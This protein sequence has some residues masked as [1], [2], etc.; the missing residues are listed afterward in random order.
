[1]LCD[2]HCHFFSEGFLSALA[3]QRGRREPT[4][5]LVRELQWEPPGSSAALADRWVRELDAHGVAR[6]ALIGSV[7][8][9]EVQVAEA[10]ARHPKRFVGF[11]MVDPAAADAVERTRRGLMDHHLA[12]VCLFPAMHGVPLHDVRT[13]R[14]LEVIGSNAGVAAFVHCGMLSVGVRKKL[15]LPSRFDLRL[16][17]P[18][19]LQPLAAAYPQI[20]FIIPHFGGGL[21]REALIAA[22]A[23]ENVH[24]DTS[25]SNR[26]I[27][28]TPGLTLQD[29]FRTAL[30]VDQALILGGNFDR[31]FP[32]PS[33]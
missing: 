11:F 30:E 1:M 29:V 26:W 21:F 10:V 27:R 19:E 31:L 12:A 22:D 5:D 16:G 4:A 28:Y 2:A 15:G 20:P 23:C 3:H 33:R 7:S 25:S 32:L 17:N 13:R 6:A 18:L 14:V 9:D 8:R 24:F